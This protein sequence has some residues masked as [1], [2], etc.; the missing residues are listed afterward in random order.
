MPELKTDAMFMS[1]SVPASEADLEKLKQ[2]L[3]N[4]GCTEPIIT[5]NRII[6][7]GHKRYKI[8][9]MF[10]IKY[11]LIETNYATREE[12]IITVC[13][14]RVKQIQPFTPAYRY[15][16]GKWYVNLKEKYRLKQTKNSTTLLMITDNS[17]NEVRAYDRAV[18]EIKHELNISVSSIAKFGTFSEIMDRILATTPSLFHDILSNRTLV[19]YQEM[20]KLN[21]AEEMEIRRFCRK[22]VNPDEIR[23]RIRTPG[24]EKK[25]AVSHSD[26]N[27]KSILNTGVKEMP[28]S[29]PDRELRGLTFTVPMWISAISRAMNHTDISESTDTAKRQLSAAL[30]KLNEQIKNTLEALK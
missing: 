8:C 22:Y 16:V 26:R 14:D 23:M 13:R 15:L 6:I 30:T 25:R 28:V 2:S 21:R 17:G 9:K 27:D 7:D 18:Q 12:A 11:S 19:A 5:W 10:K 29:D 20:L 1:L 3:L 4:E 24:N